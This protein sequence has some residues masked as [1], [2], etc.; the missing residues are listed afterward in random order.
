MGWPGGVTSAIHASNVWIGAMG[1]GGPTG[2]CLRSNVS[3]VEGV[4]C[5]MAAAAPRQQWTVV[6]L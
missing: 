2:V 6:P 5:S 4:G 1:S 3:V